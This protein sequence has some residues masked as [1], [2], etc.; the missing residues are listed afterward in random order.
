[1]DVFVPIPFSMMGVV[2]W[3]GGMVGYIQ[4]VFALPSLI[5]QPFMI[6]LSFPGVLRITQFSKKDG[7][8]CHE[9]IYKA[10]HFS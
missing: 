10:P 8:V 9:I 6:P 4:T 3:V 2:R 7:V 1:M 5:F